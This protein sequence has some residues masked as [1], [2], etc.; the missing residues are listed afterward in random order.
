MAA[1]SENASNQIMKEY[2]WYNSY[3]LA[4]DLQ[5]VVLRAEFS[6]DLVIEHDL[7]QLLSIDATVISCQ[8]TMHD[9]P[10]RSLLSQPDN[11]LNTH[12]W[13][14]LMCFPVKFRDLSL[15]SIIT[16]TIRSF[17]G[18]V[19]A[20]TSMRM[21]DENGLIKQG[22]QKLM[23][24]FN[25]AGDPNVVMENN[26]TPGEYYS[27]WA[28]HDH[29]FIME[30]RLEYFRSASSQGTNC[31]WLDKLLLQRINESLKT[32]SSF[33]TSSYDGRSESV[34]DTL[35]DNWGKPTEELELKKFSYL[36]IE[37]PI[38]PHAVGIII[39]DFSYMILNFLFCRF[40]MKRSNINR[41][42]PT[43]P[44]RR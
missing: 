33:T 11:K 5:C 19:I 40:C 15:D 38:W 18:K 37:M 25:Q 10:A 16:F 39:L 7:P 42:N 12:H 35:Y 2:K 31:A 14:N 34:S 30:K 24:F 27:H 43:I 28:K 23:L 26:K 20:G 1:I 29:Q 32:D 4:N 22:K 21:F 13:G 41:L 36:V 8:I 6:E 9:P 3:S 44:P 17:D